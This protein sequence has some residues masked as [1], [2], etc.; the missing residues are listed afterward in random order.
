M[1]LETKGVVHMALLFGSTWVVNSIVFFAI[2]LMILLSNLFTL[3]FKPRV[4]WPYYLLLIMAL[5]V[6]VYVPMSDFLNLPRAA[7]IVASC[8][9]VF[10]PVFFA[11]VI[12]AASFRDSRQPD[13]DF[14]SNI[15]GVILGGLSENLSL[16]VGFNHLLLIA[17][18]FYVLSAVLGPASRTAIAVSAGSAK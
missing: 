7:R 8:A 11:G 9:V 5:L 13:L 10:V 17:I 1:L 2:L 3:A 15:G 18:T 14:G 16:V 12:F 4:L 6:N